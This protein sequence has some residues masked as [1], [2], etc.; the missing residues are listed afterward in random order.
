MFCFQVF[1]LLTKISILYVVHSD[2]K[3]V[4]NV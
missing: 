1:S 3:Y 2:A 4:Y